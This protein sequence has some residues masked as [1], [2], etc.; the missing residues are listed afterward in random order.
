MQ[1]KK[2]RRRMSRNHLVDIGTPKQP[3]LIPRWQVGKDP[4]ELAQLLR[5]RRLNPQDP[6]FEGGEGNYKAK[7]EPLALNA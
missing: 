3:L 1:L 6:M 2:Y 7:T 5:S 4:V